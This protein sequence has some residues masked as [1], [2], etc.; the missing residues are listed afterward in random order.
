MHIYFFY[1]FIFAYLLYI[2]TFRIHE[3]HRIQL[4]RVI[5][6]FNFAAR[7]SLKN[8]FIRRFSR[9]VDGAGNLDSL[10]A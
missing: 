6:P 10:E 7:S 5:L 8:F 1:L 9:S 2:Y 4:Q 3:S